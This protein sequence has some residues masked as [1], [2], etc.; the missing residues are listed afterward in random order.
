MPENSMIDLTADIV[1]AHVSNNNTATADLPGLIQSVFAALSATANPVEP[2]TPKQEPAVS[3]RSSIKH[4]YIV[5]LEDG[6]KAEDAESAIS[7]RTSIC[8]RTSIARSGALRR[9][10]RW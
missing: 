6:A 3:V 4:D 5:C 2:E 1:S 10:T 9:I 8:R 7:A